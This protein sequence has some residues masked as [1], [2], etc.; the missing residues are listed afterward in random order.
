MNLDLDQLGVGQ[1]LILG[2]KELL[3]TEIKTSFSR[4][5]AMHVLAVSG[6]HVGIILAFLIF[7]LERFPRIFSRRAA[8]LISIL[9]IW[10]Y[11]GITG[12]SPSVLRATIMFSI[13]V[14][15]DVFGKQSSRFNSLGFSAFLMIVWNPLIIYDIGFQLSYLAMLGIFLF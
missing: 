1:A 14:F 10:I 11:A 13:I 3:S 6:L 8:I 2:N 15:G 5:G 4:A 12:F 9:F 7:V